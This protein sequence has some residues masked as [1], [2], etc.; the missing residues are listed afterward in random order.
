MKTK[1]F[2]NWKGVGERESG[3]KMIATRY[4]DKK[5]TT[6]ISRNSGSLFELG[7][8]GK[9]GICRVIRNSGRHYGNT[10]G[11]GGGLEAWEN[12]YLSNSGFKE[13]GNMPF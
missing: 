2:A 3:L 5:T 12:W 11:V 9:E 6:G 13:K 1:V 8:F 4:R 7:R 10:G